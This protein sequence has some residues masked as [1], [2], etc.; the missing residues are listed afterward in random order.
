MHEDRNG[1]QDRTWILHTGL[2]LLTSLPQPPQQP[3]PRSATQRQLAVAPAEA[4]QLDGNFCGTRCVRTD[5]RTG[6]TVSAEAH[7]VA[8]RRRKRVKG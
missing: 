5:G 1:I 7:G 8:D 6:I 4:R 3:Q 2:G